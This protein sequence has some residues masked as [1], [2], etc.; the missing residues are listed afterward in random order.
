MT[1]TSMWTEEKIAQATRVSRE[2]FAKYIARLEMPVEEELA[3]SAQLDKWYGDRREFYK[4]RKESML[5]RTKDPLWEHSRVMNQQ[6]KACAYITRAAGDAFT[7]SKCVNCGT[8]IMNA[9]TDVDVLCKHCASILGCCTHCGAEM[10]E[11]C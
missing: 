10:E 7:R 9:S 1:E 11:P 8:L 6:C 2:K 3:Q 4:I 5:K